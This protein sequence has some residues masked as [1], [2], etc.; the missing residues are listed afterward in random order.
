MGAT[1]DRASKL[2]HLSNYRSGSSG[3]VIQSY[4]CPL[5]VTRSVLA[6]M[7]ASNCW[8]FCGGHDCIS[9]YFR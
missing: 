1:D 8:T 5:I 7:R 6:A 3:F 9:V 2:V 4:I